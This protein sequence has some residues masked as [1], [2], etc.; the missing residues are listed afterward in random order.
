VYYSWLTNAVLTEEIIPARLVILSALGAMLVA[1]LAVPDAFGEYEVLF[2]LAY[3]VV[4]LLHVVVYA[5]ATGQTPETQRAVLRLA[6]GL[7]GGPVLLIAAGFPDGLA[8]GRSGP[9]P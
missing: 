2:G 7:L 1:S 5:L 4:R 9:W 3:C 6:P 8:Q